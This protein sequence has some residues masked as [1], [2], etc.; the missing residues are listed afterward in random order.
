MIK[1]SI[2]L[3]QIPGVTVAEMVEWG[4]EGERLGYAKCWAADQGLDTRDVFV[5]LTAIAQQTSAVRLGTGIT[6][7]YSRHPAVTAA[8]IATLDELSGGRAF[9][10]IGAGG[11]DTLQPMG[12]ERRKP[13][14]A[15]REMIQATRALFRGE[16]VTF[17]GE[18]IR[19]N[20]ARI[21]Y[22]RPE[23]EIWVA[24]RGDNMLKAGGELAD[25]VMFGF[26]H[27][28]TFQDY[29][30]L[31]R[32]GARVSGNKPKICYYATLITSEQM[33]DDIRPHVYHMLVDSPTHVKEM[34][35]ISSADLETIR[36]TMVSR[37][38]K[39]AGKLIK[40]EWVRPFVIM[41]SMSECAA[42]LTL[43]MTRFGIDECLL[44]IL[45]TK[46]ATDLMAQVAERLVLRRS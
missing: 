26:I 40:D 35:G 34:L 6:N 45:E 9:L 23:I 2:L 38:L 21:A 46:T 28:D 44:P 25:G 14:T 7:P 8:S 43:L 41:G 12:L 29:I 20:E 18:A 13:V 5:T 37:G 11:L 30:D 33:L 1:G 17:R 10:G 16:A 39:E 24:G 31:V 22:A 15:V 42:E 27:K 36:Q 4:R 32:T 19:L 3:N